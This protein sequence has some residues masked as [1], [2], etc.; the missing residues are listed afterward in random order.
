MDIARQ[1]VTLA[2]KGTADAGRDGQVAVAFSLNADVDTEDG[3]ETIRLLQRAS[4]DNPPDL[5]L[6]ETLSLVRP[7]TYD[8]VARLLETGVPLWLSFR[9]C[10]H[11]VCGVYGEHWG[12]P[13]GDAFGRAVRRLEELGVGALAV[14]CIP[15][16]HVAGMVAWLQDFTDLPL[17]VYPNLG[18]LAA[19]GWRADHDTDGPAYAELALQWREEGAQII[20]GCCGVGP[21]HIA[22]ARAALAQS[23]AGSEV[24]TN[25]PRVAYQSPPGP[26]VGA[27]ESWRDDAGR[28][29]YPLAFP[30]L[31]VDSGVF[32]PTQ[33]SFLVW[34]HLFAHGIGASVALT[35]AAGAGF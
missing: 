26:P 9:R 6:L 29:M 30:E 13:E 28:L 22:A 15:P 19:G 32:A 23:E 24:A 16:D 25:R 27:P 1:A 2:R 33:G 14:N 17:G 5:I 12:G 18:Y 8:T 34:K 7:S 20:G 31:R 21:D 10:R 11:G 4:Q 35:S 3:H